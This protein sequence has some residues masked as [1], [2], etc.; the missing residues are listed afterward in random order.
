MWSYPNNSSEVTVEY[1][2][3][4]DRVSYPTINNYDNFYLLAPFPTRQSLVSKSNSA[5]HP[6]FKMEEPIYDAR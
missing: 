6:S 3:L 4:E 5:F 2:I 1:S